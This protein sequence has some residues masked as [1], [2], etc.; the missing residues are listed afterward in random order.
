MTSEMRAARESCADQSDFDLNRL[1][2]AAG[3]PPAEDED[4]PMPAR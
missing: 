1:N 4:A 2:A 3:I